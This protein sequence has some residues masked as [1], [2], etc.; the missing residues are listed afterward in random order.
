MDR[1]S[2]L[3]Q[4][5]CLTDTAILRA[6]QMSVDLLRKQAID[7]PRRTEVRMRNIILEETSSK[8]MRDMIT[9]LSD[10][11]LKFYLKVLELQSDPMY[12]EINVK[13][14][15]TMGAVIS[16]ILERLEKINER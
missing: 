9:S 3:T 15:P 16:R 13:S 12:A 4:A 11:E 8:E 6:V 2:L 10:Q 7:L 14:I 5:F 1:N